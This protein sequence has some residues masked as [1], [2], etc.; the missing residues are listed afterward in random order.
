VKLRESRAAVEREPAVL[1]TDEEWAELVDAIDS[2]IEKLEA[3]PNWEGIGRRRALNN[4]FEKLA[5]TRRKE[6]R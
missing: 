3:L 4:A 2:H 1:F 5:V 6:R